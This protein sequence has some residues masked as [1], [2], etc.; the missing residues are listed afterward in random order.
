MMELMVSMFVFITG[1]SGVI[2]L[3]IGIMQNNSMANDISLASNLS[4]SSL[5]RLRISD[6]D[7][8]VGT[9]NCPPVD[10]TFDM[11]CYFLKNGAGYTSPGVMVTASEAYF[12][13]TWEAVYVPVMQVTDVTVTIDWKFSMSGGVTDSPRSVKMTGRLYPR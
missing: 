12:T 10:M 2:A 8:V 3:H 4:M 6:F 11:E 9:S 7:M 5:E 13:R 1:M